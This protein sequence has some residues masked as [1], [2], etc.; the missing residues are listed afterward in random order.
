MT[1]TFFDPPQTMR[2]ETRIRA[3]RD[4]DCKSAFRSAR[5]T[6][7]RPLQRPRALGEGLVIG[8]EKMSKRAALSLRVS[9]QSIM[10]NQHPRKMQRVFSRTFHYFLWVLPGKELGR[11]GFIR[12]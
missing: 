6:P 4:I 7:D 5:N 12:G 3:S 1:S 10:L 8:G 11:R 9:R 2:D